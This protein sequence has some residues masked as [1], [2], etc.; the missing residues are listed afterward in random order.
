[1][2]ALR[3]DKR[4]A[5]VMSLNYPTP[6]HSLISY[7]VA[8]ANDTSFT[9][10]Q[11]EWIGLGVFSWHTLGVEFLWHADPSESDV[12]FTHWADDN[13]TEPVSASAAESP[14]VH[15]RTR[16]DSRADLIRC[17]AT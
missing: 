17:T 4:R 14:E 11:R 6:R 10:E 16:V 7:R 5:D 8:F 13:S 12:L 2:R 3:A 15:A 1:M 9:R